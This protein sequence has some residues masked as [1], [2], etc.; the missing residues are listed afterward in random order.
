[1]ADIFSI[2]ISGLNVARKGMETTSHNVANSNTEGFTRQRVDIT[3]AVPVV[4]DGLTQGTGARV[5]GIRRIGDPFIEKKLLMVTTDDNYYELLAN[6]LGQLENV[7][8]DIDGEG[9]N[10]TL[11]RFFNSFSELAGNPE[12]EAIRSYVRENAAMV[13]ADFTK[14]NNNLTG[15]ARDMDTQ[16]IMQI[17]DINDLA[18]QVATLNKKITLMVANGGNANDLMDQRDMAVRNISKFLKVTT[19]EDNRFNYNVNI[20]GAG[21]LVSGGIVNPL[22]IAPF[23]D[24]NGNITHGLEVFFEARPSFPI[25]VKIKNGSLGA[26][27]YAKNDIVGSIRN[28]LDNIAFGLVKTVNSIHQKGYVNRQIT[29]GPEETPPASDAFGP[30]TGINFFKDIEGPSGA[31]SQVELSD[32]VKADLSNI[33]TGLLPSM[34]GDNRV[35]LAI[36]KVPHQKLL[37]NGRAT[38]EEEYLKSIADVGMAAGKAKLNHEQSQGILAQIKSLKERISGVSLDE[39]AVNLIKYQNAYQASAKVIKES[40]QMINAVL[41]LKR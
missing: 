5:A 38:L 32:L 26:A 7:F 34:P 8:G 9:F 22:Q 30:T 17:D 37:D 11:T 35:A 31:S 6:K 40:E 39:E 10:K 15:V 27:I 12:D 24:K 23:K 4:K 18:N 21:T 20:D 1:V 28:K 19:Y 25:T 2:G 29:N 33:T 14:M 36:S 3:T 13:T 41:D 16:I